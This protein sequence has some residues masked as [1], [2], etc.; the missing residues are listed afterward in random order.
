MVVDDLVAREESHGVAVLGKGI[1][2][3]EDALE[4]DGVVRG[5]RVVTVDRVQGVVGIKDD[6]DAGL[7]E[8][9]HALIVVLGVVGR[10]HTDGVDAELL[11]L[12]DVG[13]A[14]LG[15]GQRVD[16]GGSTTWLVVDT[17][18]E[19]SLL[20]LVEGVAGGSDGLKLRLAGLEGESGSWGSVH[21]SGSRERGQNSRGLHCGV[22]WW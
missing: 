16:I 7:G 17:T 6:V 3:G 5:V 15:I 19:E 2:G 21:S 14:D 13:L 22:M 9:L 11:E 20:A 10:V 4:V 8:L 12:L 1:N 18:D